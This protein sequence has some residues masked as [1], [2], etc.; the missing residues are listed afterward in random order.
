[1]PV[2]RSPLHLQHGAHGVM[3]QAQDCRHSPGGGQGGGAEARA[4]GL[5]PQL[6]EWSEQGV[7]DEQKGVRERQDW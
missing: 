3:L 4:G 1:M 2:C 7:E 5:G 6:Q